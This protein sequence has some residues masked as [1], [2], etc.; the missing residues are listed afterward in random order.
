MGK[1]IGAVYDEE[2]M[3]ALNAR[4]ELMEKMVSSLPTLP[5]LDSGA[6]LDERSRI[7]LDEHAVGAALRALCTYLAEVDE[8]QYWGGL[9]R[10]L[11][12]DGNILWLCHEHRQPYEVRALDQQYL[13]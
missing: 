1:A 4:A 6:H 3:E 8:H 12:P 13:G 2:A 10:T 7:G 5:G 11:T 9:E